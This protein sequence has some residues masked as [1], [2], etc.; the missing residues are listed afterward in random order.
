MISKAFF[1]MYFD[2]SIS[3]SELIV[4]IPIDASI[5]LSDLAYSANSNAVLRVRFPTSLTPRAWEGP[6]SLKVEERPQCL[7]I[8]AVQKTQVWT[9]LI[10]K[11]FPLRLWMR[12]SRIFNPLLCSFLT[13]DQ[14][15]LSCRTHHFRYVFELSSKNRIL[16]PQ[17]LPRIL[18]TK[19]E[20]PNIKKKSWK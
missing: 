13:I 2:S 3:I 9:L 4:A 7:L 18:C 11:S 6:S 16:F 12:S 8:T 5:R 20:D 10:G 1:S 19:K 15:R 14:F 17:E